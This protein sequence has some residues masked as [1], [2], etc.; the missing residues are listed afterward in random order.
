[1]PLS[2]VETNENPSGKVPAPRTIVG[3][4]GPVAV[5]WNVLGTSLLKVA[6]GR[7]VNEGSTAICTVWGL[8]FP[9]RSS[10]TGATQA[11]QVDRSTLAGVSPVK[12][13]AVQ[14]S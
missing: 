6:V 8:S 14:G 10:I 2:G 5:T 7:L 1:M 4:G 11:E 13:F 9:S 12:G 3:S